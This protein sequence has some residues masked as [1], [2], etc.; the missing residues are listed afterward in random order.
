MDSRI[1]NQDEKLWQRSAREH[2]YIHTWIYGE[3]MKTLI[4]RGRP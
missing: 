1:Q 3:T 4:T 2:A